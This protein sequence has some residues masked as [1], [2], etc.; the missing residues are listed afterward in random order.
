MIAII[1]LTEVLL[2]GYYHFMASRKAQYEI[3]YFADDNFP[4]VK[5]RY[6]PHPYL[7]YIPAPNYTNITGK[8]SHNSMGFRGPEIRKSSSN[9]IRIVTIGGSTTYNTKIEEDQKTYPAQLQTYL[10]SAQNKIEVEVINA[11]VGGYTT[12]E[13]FINF[14]FRVLEI[15]PDILIIYHAANDLH[16]QRVRNYASDNIGYRR[17][18]HLSTDWK[19]AL[20]KHSYI[21]RLFRSIFRYSKPLGVEHYTNVE[22]VDYSKPAQYIHEPYY[23]EKNLQKIIKLAKS[24]DIEV[25]LCTFASNPNFTKHYASTEYYKKGFL[26]MNTIIR[27]CSVRYDLVCVDLET[28][29]SRESLY[30]VDGVHMN[31]KGAEKKAEIIGDALLAA[32]LLRKVQAKKQ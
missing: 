27:E 20:L 7:T 13:S 31:E 30:W 12:W 10:N 22:I 4:D 29:M 21:V 3:A 18:W 19:L 5:T 28:A 25:I 6:Q 1:F 11:G 14:A 9:T 15:E 23:F 32:D 17:P 26:K 8:T 2:R 16:T 24:Y